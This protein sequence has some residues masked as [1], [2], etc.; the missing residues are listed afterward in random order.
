MASQYSEGSPSYNSGNYASLPNYYSNQP[1]MGTGVT[2]VQDSFLSTP[3][4]RTQTMSNTVPRSDPVYRSG[5]DT[6]TGVT[7]SKKGT[8]DYF[9]LNVAYKSR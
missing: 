9:T 6:L 4:L 5:Y 2:V 3:R 7:P 1:L 8:T